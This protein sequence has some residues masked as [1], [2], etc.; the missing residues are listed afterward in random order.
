MTHRFGRCPGCGTEV[1]RAWCHDARNRVFDAKPSRFL[2]THIDLDSA[3]E[4]ELTAALIR[5]KQ[6]M[7]KARQHNAALWVFNP[8]DAV[9]LP[10]AVG[11]TV[12]VR[13]GQGMTVHYCALGV[14]RSHSGQWEDLVGWYVPD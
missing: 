13:S 1:I 8:L 4:R 10:A 11:R 3:S 2:E 12:Q 6:A 9:M 14:R 7:T 5:R